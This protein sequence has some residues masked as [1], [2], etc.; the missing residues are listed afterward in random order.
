M[1]VAGLL[2]LMPKELPASWEPGCIVTSGGWPCM[3]TCEL[4][5]ESGPGS[6]D[7]RPCSPSFVALIFILSSNQSAETAMATH[8]GT[9]A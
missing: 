8:S 3:A 6:G 7:S 2:R 4:G 9:L 1:R 5:L